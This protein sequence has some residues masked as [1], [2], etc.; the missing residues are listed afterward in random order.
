MNG[1]SASVSAVNVALKKKKKPAILSVRI[2]GHCQLVVFA[3]RKHLQKAALLTFLS[4]FAKAPTL[5][6][7]LRW[8]CPSSSSE[9]EGM[10]Q[11]SRS[12]VGKGQVSCTKAGFL[13]AAPSAQAVCG[14]G[15]V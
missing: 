10:T 9:G 14:G 7:G 3:K 5:L 12:G 2:L 1:K 8:C 11:G 13:L 15:C 4:C 6:W